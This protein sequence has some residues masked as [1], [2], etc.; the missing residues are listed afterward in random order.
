MTKSQIKK[1]WEKVIDETHK[2]P[3]WEIIKKNKE[4]YQR[5][6]S[7]RELLLFCQVLLNKIESGENNA[8]NSLIFNKT[9]NF[10]CEQMGK[11]A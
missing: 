1:S 7:L 5:V 3:N 4:Q 2:L 11:Y 6:V 9:I 10:Y 8:L